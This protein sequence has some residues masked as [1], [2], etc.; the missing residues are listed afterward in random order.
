MR[1]DDGRTAGA[2]SGLIGA[3]GGWCLLVTGRLGIRLGLVHHHPVI[4]VRHPLHDRPH[5]ARHPGVLV[6]VQELD[7][8]RHLVVVPVPAGAEE[9]DRDQ[10]KDEK[11]SSERANLDYTREQKR[12]DKP[13]NQ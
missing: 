13:R 4:Q 3:C 7:L 2:R 6:E 12:E 1:R 9:G 10:G 5:E 8:I 11:E